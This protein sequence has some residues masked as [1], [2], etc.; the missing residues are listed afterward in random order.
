M[1]IKMKRLIALGS[2]IF[3]LSVFSAEP[4]H[5]R[6]GDW[7]FSGAPKGALLTDNGGWWGRSVYT[8]VTYSYEVEPGNPRDVIPGDKEGAFGR[9]ELQEYH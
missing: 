1:Q 6:G 7:D 3:S 4:I 8:G 2:A 9:T 5:W